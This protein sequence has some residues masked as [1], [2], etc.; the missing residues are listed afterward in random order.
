[1]RQVRTYRTGSLTADMPP[2]CP[3]DEG[4]ASD[5]SAVAAGYT[6]VAAVLA[7]FAFSGLILLL[8]VRLL[9]ETSDHLPRSY[10]ASL[11]AL[12]AAFISLALVAVNYAYLG[13]LQ[14]SPGPAAS[15]S[16]PYGQAFAIGGLQLVYAVLLILAT[17]EGVKATQP[18]TE[19]VFAKSTQLSTEKVF[20]TFQRVTVYF[21]TPFIALAL[22]TG[23]AEY[24]Q[25]HFGGEGAL[26]LWSWFPVAAVGVVAAWRFASR[27]WCRPMRV[28]FTGAP[29]GSATAVVAI[30][31]FATFLPFFNPADPCDT[32]PSGVVAICVAISGIAIVGLAVA[33]ARFRANQSDG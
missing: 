6:T 12:L 18:S 4:L 26:S 24:N 30:L 15:H 16:I 20:D 9:P 23:M 11:R 25:L 33:I 3:A 5:I 17:A 28:P 31:T 27:Y 14:D 19:K 8:T 29:T 13:G 32:A 10:P 22:A 7:G 2:Q 21:I 1:M